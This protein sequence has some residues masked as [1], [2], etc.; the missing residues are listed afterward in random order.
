MNQSAI[1]SLYESKHNEKG[2]VKPHDHQTHQILYSLEGEGICTLNHQAFHIVKDH[3]IIIPPK[4]KHSIAAKSKMTVLVLEFDA[5]ALSEE[6]NNQLV[7]EVFYK[8]RVHK[9]SIFDSSELRQLLRKMLYE[10]SQYNPFWHMALR[11]YMAE[12]LFIIARSSQETT[13]HMDM[14]TLRVERLKHFIETHYF[15]IKNAE[16]LSTRMG[17]S[18]RYI[19]SIFKEY[20]DM[21]PIQYLTKVRLG[22]VKQMLVETDKDIV[23]I[24][25]EVGFESLPTFYRLFKRDAGVPPNMYRESHINR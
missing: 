25:F 23:S 19:Q 21:T 4:T 24:C 18:K 11:I 7:K 1:I 15:E 12:L 13:A 16:D 3:F 10:Q 22:A 5:N 8:A 9:L 17:M 2:Q 20:Y 14:N 6:V